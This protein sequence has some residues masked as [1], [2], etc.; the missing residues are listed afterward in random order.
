M[1]FRNKRENDNPKLINLHSGHRARFRKSLIEKN[2]EGVSEHQ[3]LE[4][5]LF[6]CIP[7][8]DTN[9]IAHRL[10]DAFGSLANVLDASVE[11]L[12][13]V[14]G[15]SESA[16]TQL[17]AL[18]S[19]FKAYKKSKLQPKTNL[20]CAKE[21]FDYLGEC[22]F[23]MSKE[24]F[25]IICLDGGNNVITYHLL[26]IGSDNEVNVQ[27]KRITEIANRVNASSVILLHNHPNG[28]CEPSVEDYD[29]TK[30]IFLNLGLS[31][32]YVV[33]HIIVSSSHDYYSFSSS[34]IFKEFDKEFHSIFAQNPFRCPKP[35][36]NA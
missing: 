34:G 8:K 12:M 20:S 11:D 5:I 2:F 25:Y 3:M 23:H 22:I 24:E 18:P 15:I 27:I 13:T 14:N 9:E 17:S 29:M 16:A 32:I 36:Y 26:S 6:S 19:I 28:V 33:D 10:I 35:K 21:V 30:K 7:R 31:G 1:D 4:F